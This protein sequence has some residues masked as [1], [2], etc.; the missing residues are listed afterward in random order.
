[1]ELPRKAMGALAC[2]M[3]VLM[4]ACSPLTGKEGGWESG[5]SVDVCWK[6]AVK[7]AEMLRGGIGATVGKLLFQR[8]VT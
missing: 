5:G 3:T 1:M 8:G 6:Q 7:G 4:R 2:F